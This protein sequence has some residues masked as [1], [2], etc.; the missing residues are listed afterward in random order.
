MKREEPAGTGSPTLTDSSSAPRD[1]PDDG[2]L[3]RISKE[4][5]ELG[6]DPWRSEHVPLEEDQED[7]FAS[8]LA[9][10]LRSSSKGSSSRGTSSVGNRGTSSVG[11]RR[12]HPSTPA[13]NRFLRSHGRESST[14]SAVERALWATRL[15]AAERLIEL[16]YVPCRELER[17]TSATVSRVYSGF[18]F[19]IACKWNRF[20]G[21]PVV[22]ARTF[23][24]SWCE[25]T[26]DE[27][28]TSIDV[29]RKCGAMVWTREWD[30]RARLWLPG[31]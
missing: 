8:V 21:S 6:F 30:G 9:L 16:S 26:E 29:L 10:P 7:C 1:D 18:R 28:R 5:N 12:V 11:K 27:A 19:L 23:A 2:K 15:A 13:V 4:W 24:A 20:P 22:F 17:G 25:V 3:A 14:T 31:A